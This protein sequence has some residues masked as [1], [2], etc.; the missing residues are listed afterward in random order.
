MKNVRPMTAAEMGQKGGQ[1]RSPKKLAAIR[2]NLALANRK[3]KQL[4]QAKRL[5]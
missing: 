3:R 4:T 2:K 5:A 1:S